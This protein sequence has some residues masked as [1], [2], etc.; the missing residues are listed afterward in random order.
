MVRREFENELLSGNV[1][2]KFLSLSREELEKRFGSEF[3]KTVDFGD[4]NN[5]NHQYNLFEH[6]MRTVDN[7]KTNG[8]SQEDMLKV[9]IREGSFL[10]LSC[11]QV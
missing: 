7:V 10:L 5:N 6:I 3:V 4:Q 9:K 1:A 8:L 11:H 2:E